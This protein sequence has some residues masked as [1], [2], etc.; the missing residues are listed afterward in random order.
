MG[1]SKRNMLYVVLLVLL[2]TA[3]IY[4]IVFSFLKITNYD[5]RAVEYFPSGQ[6]QV[7]DQLP[8][9]QIRQRSGEFL[10]YNGLLVLPDELDIK[11]I[12]VPSYEGHLTLMLNDVIIF[13]DN[14][15]RISSSGGTMRDLLFEVPS[16]LISEKRNLK[17][18]LDSSTSNFIHLSGI[19]F[20]STSD[21]SL[22]IDRKQL[23]YGGIGLAIWGMQGFIFLFLV[24]LLAARSLELE[25]RPLLLIMSGLIIF[26]LGP[27]GKA[28]PKVEEVY[29]Y[30]VALLP[31]ASFGLSQFGNYLVQQRPSKYDIFFFVSSL[32][33]SIL[34]I[35]ISLGDRTDMQY[36]NLYF[37]API[38]FLTATYV[39]IRSLYRLIRNADMNSRVFGAATLTVSLALGHDVLLR[40]GVVQ[41]GFLLLPIGTLT[42]VWA[43]GSVYFNRVL[44]IRKALSSQNET[45]ALALDEQSKELEAAYEANLQDKEE[46]VVVRE[47]LTLNIELHDGVLN[48]LSF[49]SVLASDRQKD[50]VLEIEK[51]SRFAINEIRVILGSDAVQKRDLLVALATLKQQTVDLIDDVEVHWSL[52]VLLDY[53]IKHPS[54]VLAIVRIFQEAIHNA[55]VRGQCT[56]LNVSAIKNCDGGIAIIIENSGGI[57][58][59][60]SK[61]K[62]VGLESMRKRAESI[63]AGFNIVPTPSGAKLVLTLP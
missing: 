37:S 19:Y 53:Q 61:G 15:D 40:F 51:L 21:F 28:F 26:G 1:S 55:V 43:I 18:S 36:N 2:P 29:P 4:L 30:L 20:G 3:V 45:L 11:S 41:S 58:M 22:T 44:S 24:S 6:D 57:S 49:I 46:A 54:C 32:L 31:V 33:F 60:N 47:R 14:E 35:L 63:G 12:Y 10:S 52:Y 9:T 50:S 16:E 5:Y 38:V 17:F 56:L 39:T 48:Y 13:Q 34:L 27:I 62:G 42:L 23:Y 59:L 8:I 7:V 25:G